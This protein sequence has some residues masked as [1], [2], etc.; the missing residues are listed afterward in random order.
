MKKFRIVKFQTK[1]LKEITSKFIFA[2]D[3]EV[4][5]SKGKD[6][7]NLQGNEF[8]GAERVM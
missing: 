2:D 7:L 8:I 6:E 4:A 5:R 3:V 1:T